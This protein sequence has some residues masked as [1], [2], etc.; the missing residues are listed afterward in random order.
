[1]EES[2][3]RKPVFRMAMV[4]ALALSVSGVPTEGYADQATELMPQQNFVLVAQAEDDNVNDPLEPVN[5]AIFGFNEVVQSVLLRPIAELY[6][7]NLPAGFRSGVRNFLANL[8]TPVTVAND[9][10]QG[11]PQAAVVSVARFMV[12]TTAG[13]GGIADVARETGH[14]GRTED[15]GQ[16]M[17]VWGV[18]EGFY[19]VLPIFGPSNPR[20]AVGKFLVD[21][22][23][24]PVGMWVSNTNQTELEWTRQ[25]VDGLSEY[26]GVVDD[27]SQVKKTSVDYYAAIRSLYRQKRKSEIANGEQLE[28]PAIPDL[29]YD[30]VPEDFNQPLAGTS[31]TNEAAR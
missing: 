4:G 11:D 31:E 25:A 29:G 8:A 17:G 2:N 28:L 5:R 15:F 18:G 21:P 22:F 27:L 10:L 23:F 30:M 13:I 19:V 9:L 14:E 12:N 24:D 20:D 16:S 26:A 6:N 1:M 7:N 3:V